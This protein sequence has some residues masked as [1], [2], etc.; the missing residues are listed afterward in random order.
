MCV[1]EGG[2]EGKGRVVLLQQGKRKC[3][4]EAWSIVGGKWE[5]A[6]GR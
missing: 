1:C 4:G 3:E 2:G 6:V 5:G